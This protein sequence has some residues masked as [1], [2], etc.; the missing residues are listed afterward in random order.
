MYAI[1]GDN[2]LFRLVVEERDAL[3]ISCRRPEADADVVDLE[4]FPGLALDLGANLLAGPDL[5]IIGTKP[6]YKADRGH[7][8]GD[9]EESREGHK[10]PSATR[11]GASGGSGGHDS[12]VRAPR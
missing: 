5:E 2:R 3:Q 10:A 9:E 11:F 7:P 4:N 12:G 6:H 1:D 8:K